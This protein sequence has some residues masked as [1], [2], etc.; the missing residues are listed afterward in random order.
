M[1]CELNSSGFGQGLMAFFWKQT[2]K[3]WGY[4]KMRTFWRAKQ[5]SVS[6]SRLYTVAIIT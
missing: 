5:Q 6:K 2:E 3:P 1:R 4:I